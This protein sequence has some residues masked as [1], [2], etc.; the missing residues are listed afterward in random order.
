MKKFTKHASILWR[1]LL[2]G[3]LAA[4]VSE[5]LAQTAP[6]K[7]WD[8]TLGGT[9]Q[10]TISSL[11]QTLDDG[12]ILAGET[13]SPQGGDITGV[14]KGIYDVWVV[15]LNSNGVK[16]WD[17]TFGTP[18][19]D[20]IST[21]AATS[22][23]GCILG[24]TSS[25]GIVGD[26]SHA[27]KGGSDFWII[28]LD[29][30]GNKMWDKTYGGP[31]EE[32]L[33]EIHQTAD[34]GYIV[35]GTS[36]LS[37]GDRSAGFGIKDNWVL[38]LDA[39]GNKMW[40][41]SFGGNN[42]DYFASIK[43][44][45][46][47]GYIMASISGSPLSGNKSQPGRGSTDFWVIK[48]D[49][50][51]NKVWDKVFG[52]NLKDWPSDV[53]QARDGGFVVVGY[54]LSGVGNEKSQPNKGFEDYWIVKLDAAGNKLWDKTYGGDQTEGANAITQ[55]SDGGYVVTGYSNTWLFN[56][57]KTSRRGGMDI[58]TLKLDSLG[59][60]VWDQA[61][62]GAE[63]DGA[64]SMIIAK[65]G[66][67]ILAGESRSNISHDKSE[68]NLGLRD[69]WVVKLGGVITI[70][71]IEEEKS[72]AK[73]NVFPNPSQGRFQLEMKG[74]KSRSATVH[75]SDLAGKN[76]LEKQVKV[77]DGILKESF[78]L[79]AAKGVYVLQII[80]TDHIVTRKILIE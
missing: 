40:E 48:M 2:L 66:G 74:L 38:K 70:T 12:I 62:G 14:N 17:K 32:S 50:L 54:S 55:T 13:D 68:P 41:K 1:P 75:V 35:G 80:T 27:S 16:L 76:V 65:D 7:L 6:A 44:T 73:P 51:G 69:Y 37:G 25:G 61:T 31:E 19:V 60:R 46:D 77:A 4:P 63:N 72:E 3:L 49:N 18:N 42:D 20:A 29:A 57:D 64:T 56:A 11:C 53:I 8:K 52:G 39:A 24:A 43:P 34:G 9:G 26:K 71:G 23:G 78:D 22:D 36:D 28:K 58:W 47:G 21:V 15:K 5:T 33:R 79:S 59:T 45:A 67:L 10:E 30:A